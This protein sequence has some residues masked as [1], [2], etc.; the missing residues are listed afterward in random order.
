VI[1]FAAK[2]HVPEGVEIVTLADERAKDPGCLQ[3]IFDMVN[4]I[5][6]DIPNPDV[7]TS[8]TYDTFL[9]GI[10]NPDALHDGYF[11]AKAGGRYVGLSNLWRSEGS[12]DALYQGLTGVVR[13]H[14]GRGLEGIGQAGATNAAL[15]AVALLAL[16][17][18]KLA[19][20]LDE[21]RR[22]QTEAVLK[23]APLKL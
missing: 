7:Y 19:L 2:A 17:D 6:P 23:A 4:E 9:S 21:F 1:R 11:L 5:G 14:R 15:F 8:P 12:P 22:K 16:S 13:E 18:R 10:E 20:K 3:G